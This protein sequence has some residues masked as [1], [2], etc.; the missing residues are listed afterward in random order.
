MTSSSSISAFLDGDGADF[1]RAVRADPAQAACP[2]ILLSANADLARPADDDGEPLFTAVME[3]P[4]DAAHLS[5]AIRVSSSCASL[6]SFRSLEGLTEQA[7]QRMRQAFHASWLA[8][9]TQL[10]S[11]DA[12]ADPEGLS[13]QAHKLAGSARMLGHDALADALR[14]FERACDSA[15]MDAKRLHAML[16]RVAEIEIPGESA[17]S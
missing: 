17:H 8:F 5:E 7:Q 10:D 9:R 3:K 6:P 4:I 16:R 13:A 11:Q 12:L 2:V 15:T 1:A 14:A